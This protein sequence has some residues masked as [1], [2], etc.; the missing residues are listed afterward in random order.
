MDSRGIMVAMRCAYIFSFIMAALASILRYRYI[1]EILVNGRGVQSDP[2][3]TVKEVLRGF[4]ETYRVL[5]A[6]LARAAGSSSS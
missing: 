1:E 4:R 2:W 6:Q 5:P 3:E